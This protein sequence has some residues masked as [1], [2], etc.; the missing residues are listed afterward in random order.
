[1]SEILPALAHSETACS[2]RGRL[3]GISS[4][5]VTWDQRMSMLE[6]QEKEIHHTQL[7]IVREQTIAFVRDLT[8]V[9]HDVAELKASIDL[10]KSSLERE[11]QERVSS[12]CQLE[13]QH[14]QFVEA[15]SS[16]L[17]TSL[18][19][20][21]Q[22]IERQLR[23][24]QLREVYSRRAESE[25]LTKG[26]MVAAQDHWALWKASSVISRSSYERCRGTSA[27]RPRRARISWKA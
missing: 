16:R 26:L 4:Q 3:Q 11:K 1:M 14:A 12:F 17:A 25:E 21:M 27:R 9:R 8:N 19:A 13:T 23:E 10:V 20:K 2:S 7:K 18:E 24:E 6:T 5:Q 15:S 22:G